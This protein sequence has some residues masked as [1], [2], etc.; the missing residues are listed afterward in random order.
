MYHCPHRHNIFRLLFLKCQILLN[1]PLVLFTLITAIVPRKAIILKCS[2]NCCWNRF[3]IVI[4]LVVYLIKDY[5]NILLMHA[6]YF[7]DSLS[8]PQWWMCMQRELRVKIFFLHFTFYGFY[9]LTVYSKNT[10][11]WQTRA[12]KT[13]EQAVI[14][15][16]C[17]ELCKNEKLENR[18]VSSGLCLGSVWLKM[19]SS[20]T[21][22]RRPFTNMW[23]QVKLNNC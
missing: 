7:S 16:V 3:K 12:E 13:R 18:R 1:A 23:L 4:N 15:E 6:Q 10:P 9:S 5:Y 17:L 2:N 21:R 20:G 11:S 19:T 8:D 22:W 14:W